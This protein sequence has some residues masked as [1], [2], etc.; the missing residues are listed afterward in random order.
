MPYTSDRGLLAFLVRQKCLVWNMVLAPRHAGRFRLF[1]VN[2]RF[3]AGPLMRVCQYLR[4]EV[5][6]SLDLAFRVQQN[7][8]LHRSATPEGREVPGRPKRTAG[9]YQNHYDTKKADGNPPA[10]SVWI[11]E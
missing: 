1:Q 5:W 7:P 9:A 10:F 3:P 4:S 6:E 2:F 8:I 11:E